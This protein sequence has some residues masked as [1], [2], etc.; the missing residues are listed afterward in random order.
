L[1]REFIRRPTGDL[2][3]K[4]VGII[5]F[6]G[7]GRRLAQ[8]LA[9]FRVR[10]LATD[11]FPVQRPAEV[12]ALWPADRLEELLPQADVLILCM[13]L[14]DETRGMIGAEHLAAMKPGSL[15]IN[16]ARGPVVDE[17]ALVAALESG[18]LAGAGLDVTQVEPLPEESPLW[19]MPQ[20]II[21]PHVG[22]QSATRQDDV[23]AFF[24]ENLQR[25]RNQRPL[26][27][28][29]MRKELGFPCPEHAAWYRGRPP[30]S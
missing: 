12:E 17:T 27:N 16:V 24:C 22:A 7:N 25:Y 10:I 23:T 6:G 15:L 11:V 26:L 19:E 28:L 3:G 8:I 18:H 5:G 29:L 1:K 14:N 21:T 4:T 2:H 20:V 13:P 9:P 30:R